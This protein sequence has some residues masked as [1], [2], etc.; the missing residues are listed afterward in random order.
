MEKKIEDY[1][2]EKGE[3][4]LDLGINSINIYE[5]EG[6]DYLKKR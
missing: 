2:K 6:A 1:I 3:K 5:F 4:L